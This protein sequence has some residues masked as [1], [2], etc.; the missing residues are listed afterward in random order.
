MG[1]KYKKIGFLK[2]ILSPPNIDIKKPILSLNILSN[3]TIKQTPVLFGESDLLKEDLDSEKKADKPKD[4]NVSENEDKLEV[5]KNDTLDENNKNIDASEINN[6][7]NKN[8]ESG[9]KEKDK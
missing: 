6:E 8:I 7:S 3:K 4:S 9:D 1:F 2:K 5:K